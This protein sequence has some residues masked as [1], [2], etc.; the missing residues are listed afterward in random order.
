MIIEEIVRLTFYSVDS[1]VEP[2]STMTASGWATRVRRSDESRRLPTEFETNHREGVA[3]H[4]P[5][6]RVDVDRRQNAQNACLLA[7]S[8]S[9]IRREGTHEEKTALIHKKYRYQFILIVRR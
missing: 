5:V 9:E 1:T 3:V 8:G 4:T 2:N 6:A 7:F